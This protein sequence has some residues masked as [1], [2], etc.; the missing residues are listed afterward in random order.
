M[1]KFFLMTACFLAVV[2]AGAQTL[3]EIVS[4]YTV[5][6]KLDKISGF[7]TLKITGNMSVSGMELPMEIWMKNPDKIKTVTSFNGSEIAQAYDGEKGYSINPMTGSTDPVEMTADQIRDLSRNNMF[8]NYLSN[9]LKNGQL[10]LAGEDNVNGKPVFKIN[11]KL[12]GGTSATLFIDKSSWL[13]VK[14]TADVNQGGMAMTVE[15]YPSDYK[16]NN[17]VM[18][19][20]KTTTS[21]GGMEMV[22]TFTKVEVDLPMED[23]VFRLK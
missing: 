22:T 12:E 2:T 16:D 13:L 17:G 9:Y 5:A 18:I 23:S 6:N 10:T 3:E 11:A 14:T 19:P 8:Q 20:M 21:A 7:K 1:K 4:N 15:S